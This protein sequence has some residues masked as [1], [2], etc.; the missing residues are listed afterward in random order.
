ME[1][2]GY[3]KENFSSAS[4]SALSKH[5]PTK[6]GSR[7]RRGLR[8]VSCN[9]AGSSPVSRR[10]AYTINHEE[11]MEFFFA[12]PAED[13]IENDDV[14]TFL[15][16][17]E[18]LDEP[19]EQGPPSPGPDKYEDI[20]PFEDRLSLFPSSAFEKIYTLSTRADETLDIDDNLVFDDE[21][22]EALDAELIELTDALK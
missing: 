5:S 10:R 2:V 4:R 8:P 17:L 11:N 22:V 19:V 1:N 20:L 14:K 18:D 9:L 15:G 6:T 21:D 16:K 3:K 13:S 12:K 7:A